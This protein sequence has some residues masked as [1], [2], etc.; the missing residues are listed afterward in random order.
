[1]AKQLDPNWLVMQGATENDREKVRH[2]LKRREEALGAH[3]FYTEDDFVTLTLGSNLISLRQ[4]AA[5]SSIE[6][7]DEIFRENDHFLHEE[8]SVSG[9]EFVLDIGA[10]EGFY[11][12]RAATT[13]PGV[14]I[15]CVEP[16]PFAFEILVKN[17]ENNALEN[18]IPVNAAVSSDGRPIGMEFVRQISAIG[19]ARLR[20][21]NR[22]WLPE[23]VVDKRTVSSITIKG[24]LRRYS[25]PRVDILKVDVEGMEDEIMGSLEPIAGRI[26]RIVVERHSR[27]LRDVVKNRLLRLGFKLVLE[28]DPECERYYGD[29]YFINEGVN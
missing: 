11:A 17:M 12:L 18:V 1:M 27:K 26:R 28:E 13:N 2:I 16:N 22:P 25:F 14:R 21:M 4:C 24:L 29:L 6:V 7:Y 5:S 20:D 15:V 19:G 3:K 10:N 23:D 9:A 8:F